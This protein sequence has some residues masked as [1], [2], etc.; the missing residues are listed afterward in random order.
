MSQFDLSD[1]VAKIHS[2]RVKRS[3]S[4]CAFYS[5][6]GD[7]L[8][9]YLTG[10]EFVA[11]R[12]DG[13]LT[14]YVSP[15]STSEVFGF[16]LKDLKRNLREADIRWSSNKVLSGAY[17]L[18]LAVYLWERTHAESGRKDGPE[19]RTRESLL[20]LY[21]EHADERIQFRNPGALVTK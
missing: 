10:D 1:L 7:S 3:F 16:A 13:F 12:V 8:E 4:P 21:R 15:E 2:R 17:L 9:V 18:S 11:R 19:R 20:E 6:E 14:F 5:V